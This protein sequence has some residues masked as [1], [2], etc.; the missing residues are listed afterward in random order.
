MENTKVNRTEK[1]FG[2]DA[3]QTKGPGQDGFANKEY[4]KPNDAHDH[5]TDDEHMQID[6]EGGEIDSDDQV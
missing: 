5:N 1:A 4:I 2:E 3:Q 6:E